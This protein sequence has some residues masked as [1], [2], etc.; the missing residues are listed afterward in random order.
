MRW[1]ARR[2]IVKARMVKL[3]GPGSKAAYAHLR[4]LLREGA[5]LDRSAEDIAA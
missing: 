4:Y 5:S 3:A 1:R 2:V